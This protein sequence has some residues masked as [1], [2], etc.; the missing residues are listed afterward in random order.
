MRPPSGRRAFLGSAAA[1]G[2][3]FWLPRAA[4]GQAPVGAGELVPRRLYSLE[5]DYGNVRISPDGNQLAY[6]APVDGIRNLF[7]APVAEPRKAR[8][9]TRVTD[10]NIG[11]Y[12]QWA[13]TNRHL[14]YAR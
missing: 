12:Y 14:I 2:G 9:V 13:N 11:W 1:L 10:R 5:P 7:V 3:A 6:L 4:W 8:Q